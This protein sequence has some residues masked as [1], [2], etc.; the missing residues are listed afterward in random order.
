MFLNPI[1]DVIARCTPECGVIFQKWQVG[2]RAV[3]FGVAGGRRLPTAVLP[4]LLTIGYSTDVRL[5]RGLG[6]FWRG[7]FRD[8]IGLK[9]RAAPG[10]SRAP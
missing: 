9:R 2:R 7:N 5:A 3:Y 8:W 1:S 4:D 10:A 6:A